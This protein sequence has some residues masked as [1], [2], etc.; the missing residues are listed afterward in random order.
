[1]LINVNQHA[2]YSSL[3][4]ELKPDTKKKSEKLQIWFWT[5]H[6]QKH[7][8]EQGIYFPTVSRS[9]MSVRPD[10]DVWRATERIDKYLPNQLSKSRVTAHTLCNFLVRQKFP[11]IVSKYLKRS[12]E[13]ISNIAHV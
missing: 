7:F 11:F 12:D 13:S 6:L 1:M 4:H 9:E 3:P 10:L 2:Y 5:K 8:F